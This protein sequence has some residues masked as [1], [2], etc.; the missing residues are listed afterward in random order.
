MPWPMR[1]LQIPI[2]F[3]YLRSSRHPWT[4]AERVWWAK[5]KTFGTMLTL[6]KVGN[7]V[8]LFIGDYLTGWTVSGLYT[9]LYDTIT[10]NPAAAHGREGVYIG[11][12]GQH[13][14][15][16]V[17]KAVQEAMIELDLSKETEPSSFTREEVEKYFGVGRHFQPR[18][19]PHST[20]F[21]RTITLEW[22]LI[23][24]PR[25]LGQLDGSLPRQL[26]IS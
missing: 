6:T 11:E 13:T 2:L 14:L 8:F 18:C 3:R 16:D 25:G 19:G 7:R 20:D 1:G 21:C 15:Y 26:K 23:V 22:T 12:N 10:S 9:I 5:G 24:G 17:A 4:E